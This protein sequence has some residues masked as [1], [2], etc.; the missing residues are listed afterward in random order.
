MAWPEN[1]TDVDFEYITPDKGLGE[2][3]ASVGDGL[4]TPMEVVVVVVTPLRTPVA[5]RV[6]AVPAVP[7]SVQEIAPKEVVHPPPLVPVSEHPDPMYT[8]VA[9]RVPPLAESVIWIWLPPVLTA[10]LPYVSVIL[11]SMYRVAPVAPF[12]AV[13]VKGAS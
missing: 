7:G 1:T 8:L 9:L 12:L 13:D 4:T 6:T 5:V 10:V 11:T 3:T 2:V